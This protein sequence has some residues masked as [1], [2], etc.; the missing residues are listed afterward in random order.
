MA[1]SM[2]THTVHLLMICPGKVLVACDH[3]RTGRTGQTDRQM[4][5]PLPLIMMVADLQWVSKEYLHCTIQQRNCQQLE[6]GT[7]QYEN[8]N[9]KIVCASIRII[10]YHIAYIFQGRK[11]S[12]NF[13][14]FSITTKNLTL[15]I[16]L[17]TAIWWLCNTV[18]PQLSGPWLF[19]HLVIRIVLSQIPQ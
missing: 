18:V 11:V 16:L 5:T 2:P 15:K 19:E 10:K 1:I 7:G 13:V 4:N 17:Y 8:V 3:I 14:D 6:I 12:Q 9:T